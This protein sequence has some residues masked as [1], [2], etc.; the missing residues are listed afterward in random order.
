MLW[1]D[2]STF[3]LVSRKNGFRVLSP[4]DT[5]QTFIATEAK[6]NVCHG[7]VVQQS[8]QHGWL[9]Y[10][11]RYYWYG[12]IYWD[13]TETYTAIKMMSFMGSPWLLDQDNASSHSACATTTWFRRQ[14]ECVRLARLQ[15]RSDSYWKCMT[16]HEKE[17]QTMTITHCW[18]FEVLYQV[19]LDKNFACKSLKICILKSKRM[20]KSQILDFIA[21]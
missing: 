12:G 8:K 2:E 21:L 3:Q 19:R 7:M 4:K 20:N 15:S 9:A 18:A 13:C 14:S 17:N 10:V 11:W 1:S 16:S 6:A 5:I